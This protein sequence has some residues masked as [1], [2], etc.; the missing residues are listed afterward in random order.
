MRYVKRDTVIGL[1]QE[2]ED[3]LIIR[4]AAHT[5]DKYAPSGNLGCLLETSSVVAWRFLHDADGRLYADLVQSVL[6][7]C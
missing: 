7:T 4:Q 2:Q 3:F 5:T 1:C 6:R